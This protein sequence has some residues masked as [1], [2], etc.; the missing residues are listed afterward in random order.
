MYNTLKYFRQTTMQAGKRILTPE[1]PN[2]NRKSLTKTS[3]PIIQKSPK[4]QKQSFLLPI[5]TKNKI[6]THLIPKS[7]DHNTASPSIE[8]EIK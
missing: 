6:V 3:Q 4:P 1:Y 5:I 2:P 8:K 7:H